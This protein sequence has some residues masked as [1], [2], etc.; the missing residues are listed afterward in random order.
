VTI[1]ESHVEHHL[2]RRVKAV[3]GFVRK[4]KWIGRQGAPDRFVAIPDPH[5][6]R[7]MWLIELKRPGKGAEDHQER[8]HKRLREAGVRVIVLDSVDAVD[9]WLD[10]A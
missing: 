6:R 9:T 10:A 3:Q 7:G 4:L 5:P 8:E 1:R 2:V